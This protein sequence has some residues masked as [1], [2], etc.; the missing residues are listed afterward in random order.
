MIFADTDRDAI[1]YAGELFVKSAL[2][3][4]RDDHAAATCYEE[5]A[6]MLAPGR[7]PI[8][9]RSAIEAFLSSFPPFSD[10]RLEVA[11][12]VGHGDLAFERGIASMTLHREGTV[13]E[14]TRMQYV[15]IWRRQTD[16]SWRAAREI[17]TPG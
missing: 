15:V 16:G 8:R 13:G 12:I 5:E 1:R 10:Y 6:I 7:Q 17:L 4:P 11:E 14:A 3:H 9:G 2:A